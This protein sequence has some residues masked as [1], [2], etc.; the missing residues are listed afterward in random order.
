LV[1][2]EKSEEEV[3]DSPGLQ[4]YVPRYGLLENTYQQNVPDMT[5]ERTLS[6]CI[7]IEYGVQSRDLTSSNQHQIWKIDE[8]S[9]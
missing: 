3:K 6:L 4:N 2:S 9:K 8:L 7:S 1:D 5:G